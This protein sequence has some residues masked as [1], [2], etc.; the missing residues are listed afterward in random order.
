MLFMA[1]IAFTIFMY[2]ILIALV[3]RLI[4]NDM[5]KLVYII[6][7]VILAGISED[8]FINSSMNIFFTIFITS[9]GLLLKG[10][11]ENLQ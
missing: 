3:R 6:L 4:N 10:Y 7:I 2:C 9:N 8:S 1:G 11:K 5:Y